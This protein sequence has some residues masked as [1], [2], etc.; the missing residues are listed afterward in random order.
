MSRSF[1]HLGLRGTHSSPT[2][3]KEGNGNVQGAKEGVASPFISYP[4]AE[5]DQINFTDLISCIY[6][7]TKRVMDAPETQST[8]TP[9]YTETAK[10]LVEAA[11]GKC[12]SKKINEPERYDTEP[13]Y[14]RATILE[15][16]TKCLKNQS[17]I[18]EALLK[19]IETSDNDRTQKEAYVSGM[20]RSDFTEYLD[21]SEKEISGQ[22]NESLRKLATLFLIADGGQLAINTA[23]LE[24]SDSMDWV[25]FHLFTLQTY[26]GSLCL[27]VKLQNP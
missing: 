15:R 7:Y 14:F 19:R 27:I 25:K 23:Q 22:A 5:S 2:R 13:C 8:T 24:S 9:E 11:M 16:C 10:K 3:D 12:T 21:G 1:D 26:L 17:V 4:P 6:Y 18:I 20:W